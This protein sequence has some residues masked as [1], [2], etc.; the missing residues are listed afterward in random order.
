M[1]CKRTKGEA[2]GTDLG[3]C[4]PLRGKR[5][6]ASDSLPEASPGRGK[7]SRS[8]PPTQN[9]G[10]MRGK[11]LWRFAEEK[12]APKGRADRHIPPRHPD[13]NLSL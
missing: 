1:K 12:E 3:S 10:R 6:R 7:P 8:L 5:M 13:R 9:K 11:E 4:A 2:L